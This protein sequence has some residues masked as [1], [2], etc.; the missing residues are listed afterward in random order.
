MACFWLVDGDMHQTL[1]M[2]AWMEGPGMAQDPIFS[3]E[4]LVSFSRL[5]IRLFQDATLILK[6]FSRLLRRS[7]YI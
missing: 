4:I 5:P 6:T 7:I 1:Q 2:G 3:I